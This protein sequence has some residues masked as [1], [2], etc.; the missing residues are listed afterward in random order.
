MNKVTQSIYKNAVDN[1]LFDKD[2]HFR[3]IEGNGTPANVSGMTVISSKWSLNG[4][5]LMFEII[6]TFSKS[7][8]A[9]ADLCTFTLPDW[10][11]YK[12]PT[13]YLNLVDFIRFDA[14]YTNGATATGFLQIYKHENFIG[15]RNQ[16]NV[17]IDALTVFK[18]R[19]NV[20]IDYNKE[21]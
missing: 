20:I 1:A 21:A 17:T 4:S 11:I 14:V 5:N 6:G 8:N 3:F 7:L 2:G 10:I 13:P 18:I 12:I 15:F 9:G 19:Y 16:D